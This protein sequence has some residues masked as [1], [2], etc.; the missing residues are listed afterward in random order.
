MN[1][2]AWTLYGLITS[3]FGDVQVRLDTGETVEEFLRSYFGYRHEFLGVVAAIIVA[4]PALFAFIFTMAIRFFHYE[5][6]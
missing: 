2:V 5:K 3:Q 6:R 1:P 4:L